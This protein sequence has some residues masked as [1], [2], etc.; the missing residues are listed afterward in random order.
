MSCSKAMRP[1]DF[2]GKLSMQ[3]FPLGEKTQNSCPKKGIGSKKKFWLPKKVRC[4]FRFKMLSEKVCSIHHPCPFSQFFLENKKGFGSQK[5]VRCS[6]RFKMLSEKVCSIHHPC[7]FSQH[8]L[9]N[10]KGF[11]SQKRS[12]AASISKCFLKKVCSIHHPCPFSRLLFLN[13][14]GLWKVF[15]KLLRPQKTYWANAILAPPL[16]QELPP[17]QNVTCPK[18]GGMFRLRFLVGGRTSRSQQRSAT[19]C[20]P[21]Q[22]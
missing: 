1:F 14:I 6:F 9:E 18:W 7:P 10:K 8:F 15:L 20:N 12:A 3:R 16:I 4:S 21:P 19:I 5:K 22:P 11:G 13:F 2:C 17:Y